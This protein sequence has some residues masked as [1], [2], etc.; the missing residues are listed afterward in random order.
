MTQSRFLTLFSALLLLTLN[1][2]PFHAQ[3]TSNATYNT[4][5]NAASNARPPRVLNAAELRLA[6]EK[7]NVVGFERRN[8]LSVLFSE[9]RFIV[10]G[11]QIGRV[12]EDG[13]AAAKLLFGEAAGEK[14][15]GF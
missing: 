4:S 15:Y 6:L 7:I 1:A 5:Y 14:A 13:D 12:F 11:K 10:A 8:S 2:P 9:R 3:T